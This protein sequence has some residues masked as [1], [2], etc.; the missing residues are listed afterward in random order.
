LPI[1]K[2]LLGRFGHGLAEGIN[3]CVAEDDSLE[4]SEEIA[5]KRLGKISANNCDVG[6]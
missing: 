2:T 3:V 5:L 4:T 6:Q 1:F